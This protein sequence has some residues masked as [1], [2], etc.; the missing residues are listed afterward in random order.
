MIFADIGFPM[1]WL[2]PRSGLYRVAFRH[3]GRKLHY[4]VGSDNQK[5]AKACMAH[6][7]TEPAK[8]AIRTMFG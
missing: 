7:D 2:E 4:S 8:A 3:S 6:L 1:A 5:E